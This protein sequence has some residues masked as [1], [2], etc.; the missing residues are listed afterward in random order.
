M[1]NIKRVV[2]AFGLAM[3]LGGAVSGCVVREQR[4]ATGPGGCPGGVWIE[5][6]YSPRGYWHRGHWRCPGIV[7]R[8]E[9]E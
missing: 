3:A 7:D 4:V 1:L 2:S 8:I 9:I 5:G 6:H